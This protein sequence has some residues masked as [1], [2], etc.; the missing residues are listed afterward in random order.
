MTHPFNSGVKIVPRVEPEISIILPTYNRQKRLE[1]C[2]PSYLNTKLKN[3]EFIILDNCSTDE[4]WN[5][6]RKVSDRDSR[7]RL[8]KNPQNLG[9]IRTIFRGYCE[10]RS[11][12]AVFL[13]DDI[14]AKL[15]G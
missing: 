10:V 1:K 8:I 11:P 5:Y 6:L 9:P 13:A 7:I 4:T 15:C 2:L 3:V 14:R 12:F